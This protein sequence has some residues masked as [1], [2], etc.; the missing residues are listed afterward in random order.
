MEP[1]QKS[2]FS[3]DGHVHRVHLPLRARL[4]NTLSCYWEARVGHASSTPKHRCWHCTHFTTLVMA[5]SK[6]DLLDSFS[7]SI[8][9]SSS[10]SPLNIHWDTDIEDLGEFKGVTIGVCAMNSKVREKSWMDGRTFAYNRTLV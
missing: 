3:V 2:F 5:T 4:C 9:H 10:P 7:N 6:S 1:Q 8:S